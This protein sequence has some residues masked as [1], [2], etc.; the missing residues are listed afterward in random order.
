MSWG[1]CYNGNNNI[2][3]N[4]P[5]LMMDG[6]HFTSY[7]MA[8]TL[9]DSLKQKASI[10]TNSSYRNYLQVNADSI[11][12][13]NQLNACNECSTCP[14]YNDGNVGDS[15]NSPYIFKS[16]LSKD[17]PYGYESSDL[18]NIYLSSHYLN[19]QKH[20]PRFQIN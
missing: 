2:H 19:S 12:K 4:F 14:Y 16:S 7:T 10:K 9:D 1:T 11:I 13:N 20:L 17:Q 6:R 15:N 5:G 18:K 3:F 8:P